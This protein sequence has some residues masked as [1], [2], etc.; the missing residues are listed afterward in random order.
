MVI[1]VYCVETCLRSLVEKEW[2][3]GANHSGLAISL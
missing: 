3:L 1:Q 2:R